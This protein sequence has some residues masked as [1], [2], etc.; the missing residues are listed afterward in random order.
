M[1]DKYGFGPIG[2]NVGVCLPL[3]ILEMEELDTDQFV[4]AVYPNESYVKYHHEQG[5]EE[6]SMEL[7]LQL[8]ESTSHTFLD[9]VEQMRNEHS[10]SGEENDK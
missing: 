6:E 1:A 8:L 9:Y 7:A 10:K 2:G 5:D 4:T 3:F